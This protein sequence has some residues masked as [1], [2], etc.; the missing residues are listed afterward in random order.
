MSASTACVTEPSVEF[1]RGTTPY[2]ASRRV[3][4]SKTPS[5]VVASV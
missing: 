2:W 4:A 3:T 1:S 5:N